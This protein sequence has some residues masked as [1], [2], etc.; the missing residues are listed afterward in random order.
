MERP[1]VWEIWLSLHAAHQKQKNII[2]GG[3][4]RILILI[5]RY[6]ASK[7]CPYAI[8]YLQQG[9]IIVLEKPQIY[10]RTEKKE[11]KK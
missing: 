4:R 9:I 3:V 6:S 5:L 10:K 11:K 8:L 7:A 1:G 2:Y